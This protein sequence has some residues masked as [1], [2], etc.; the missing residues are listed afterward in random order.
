[1]RNRSFWAC[2][3]WNQVI[4]MQSSCVNFKMILILHICTSRM[5]WINDF[6][7]PKYRVTWTIT[8][9]VIHIEIKVWGMM[10]VHNS[11]ILRLPCFRFLNRVLCLLFMKTMSSNSFSIELLSNYQNGFV[12]IYVI[13]DN[14]QKSVIMFSPSPL[15][16]FLIHKTHFFFF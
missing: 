6:Y 14:N 4:T 3:N 1:M 15:G 7:K 10:F 5:H 12:N 8:S 2:L 16:E 13:H 11:R 9:C